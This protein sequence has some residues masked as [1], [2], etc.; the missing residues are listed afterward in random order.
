V[1]KAVNH[2]KEKGGTKKGGQIYFLY[3]KHPLLAGFCLMEWA[4]IG[5]QL[6]ADLQW[7]VS[8]ARPIVGR[9]SH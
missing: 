1:A 8:A 9:D 7:R 5:Q 2:L 3:S 6:P 4:E